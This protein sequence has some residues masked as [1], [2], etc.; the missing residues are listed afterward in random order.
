MK[1]FE[2][3]GGRIRQEMEKGKGDASIYTHPVNLEP[4]FTPFRHT[5]RSVPERQNLV[6]IRNQDS[7]NVSN[8]QELTFIR[9]RPSREARV[10]SALEEQLLLALA[11]AREVSFEVVCLRKMISMQMAVDADRCPHVIGCIHGLYPNAE[12][13]VSEDLLRPVTTESMMVSNFG[14]R[15][16]H[17]FPL[18]TD[19][20]LD[21]YGPLFGALGGLAADEFA[22]LQILFVPV[23]HDWK[24]NIV[25]ASSDEY[26]PNKSPF[27]D[28]PHLP[29]MADRKT[30]KPLYAV[31]VRTIASSDET[32]AKLEGFWRQ[33]DGD[34]GLIR[35]AQNHSPLAVMERTSYTNGMILNTEELARLVHLPSPEVLSDRVE[36]AIHGGAPPPAAKQDFLVPLG[37]NQYGGIESDTGIPLETYAKHCSIL[38]RSG[39][40]KTT[41]ILHQLS[42]LA[43]RGYGF[44]FID[45]SGD[46]ATQLLGLI[47]S[48]RQEHCV[49]FDPSDTSY[50]PGFNPIEP[51]NDRERHLLCSDLMAS[52]ENYYLDAWGPR[53]AMILRNAIWLLLQSSGNR[54]L[55]DI[56]RLLMNV[57]FREELLAEVSDPSLVSFWRDIYP[58]LPKGAA[59]PILNKLSEF[60]DNP[61]VRNVI[62]QPNLLDVGNIMREN[63]IFIASLSKGLIGDDAASL[64][65]SFL[66]ARFRIST[67]ARAGLPVQQRE[68]FPIIVDEAQN[69]ARTRA[70]ASIMTTFLS[71]ARKYGVPLV[72]ATQSF[73][74]FHPD[75]T[76]GV[77]ANAS[78]SIVF[79]CGLP[80]AHTVQKEMGCFGID[81]ILNLGVGECIVRMSASENSFR[82]KV[83]P[84]RTGDPS[85]ARDIISISRARYC[86][87]RQVVEE[88]IRDNIQSTAAPD[89]LD[90]SK[91]LSKDELRF[92]N[93]V[94]QNPERPTTATYQDL[95]LS[96]YS[97]NKLKQTLLKRGFLCEVRTKLGRGARIAKFLIPSQTACR[98]MG[99]P[100]YHGRGGPVHQYLQSYVGQQAETSGY[101]VQVEHRIPGAEGSIDVVIEREGTATAIEIAVSSTEQR[102]L[103]NIDKCLTAGYDNVLAL[104]VDPSLLDETRIL[105]SN[106]LIQSDLARVRFGLVDDV[107]RHL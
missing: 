30:S 77:L 70:N 2:I 59:Q 75:A 1:A 92:L 91:E 85:R 34:N 69:Y 93:H 21:T 99:L 19:L 43:E 79:R 58:S 42:M 24:T 46:A 103:H 5:M 106:N 26:E 47:P 28:L 41:L 10:T 18:Q 17:F 48:H 89:E 53:M 107:K 104:F 32:T 64:L 73:S 29:K 97:G 44:A 12:A 33:F 65:G 15:E 74:Q 81:D 105:A 56:I 76:A 45:P 6:S 102:E 39:E 11:S 9:I 94:W 60:I 27:Y 38:G 3:T 78:T 37:S 7:R 67:L 52:L 35:L 23:T 98:K 83:P 88:S 71:E 49:Y 90:K 80:D 68:L 36:T 8:H 50:P 86:R 63:M 84:P 87:P 62:A 55:I 40:G 14:L 61:L 66:L 4:P 22:V 16:S 100:P 72:L 25:K 96:N 82:V 95:G 54:T 57:Q 51:V 13:Y 101:S 31:S 20:R